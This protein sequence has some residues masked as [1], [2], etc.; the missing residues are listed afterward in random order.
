MFWTFTI[1]LFL[2]FIYYEEKQ[3]VFEIAAKECL[4]DFNKD[5]QYRLWATKHGGVYAPIT[6]DTSPN[7]YL[8][9]IPE[10]DI[11][12]P[13]GKK[14]TLIN[15]AYMTRQVFELGKGRFG[16]LED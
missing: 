6:G 3:A 5:V 7:P 10:S 11:T 1:I 9:H 16:Y 4:T 13:S 8:S 2:A 14:L 15:P 12:I